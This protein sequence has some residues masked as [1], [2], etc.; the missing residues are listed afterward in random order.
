MAPAQTLEAL[1]NLVPLGTDVD[2]ARGVANADVM[3][4]E[5]V[6]LG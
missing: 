4:A 5:P 3:V 6:S 1:G 2:M